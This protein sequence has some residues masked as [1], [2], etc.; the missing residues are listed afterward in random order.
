V[1][2]RWRPDD[3]D[4]QIL[5][6]GLIVRAAATVLFVAVLILVVPAPGQRL[7]SVAL[8]AIIALE[9]AVVVGW[10]LRRDCVAPVALVLDVPFGAALIVAGTYLTASG[11][12]GDWSAFVLSYTV[13]AS[14]TVGFASRGIGSAALNGLVWGLAGFGS[15]VTIAHQA[16]LA[17]AFLLPSY[18][19]NPIVGATCA[20][21][22][23]SSATVFEAARGAELRYAA[24][25]AE[26]RERVR[27]GQVLHDRILQTMETLAREGVIGDDRVRERVR[28]QAAWLRRFVETPDLVPDGFSERLTTVAR[29][30]ER[31]GTRV[32]LN[33]AA[34]LVHPVVLAPQRSDVVIGSIRRLLA[35]LGGPGARVVMRVTVES[36]AVL[37]TLL[38]LS[39]RGALPEDEVEK[40]RAEVLAVGGELEVEPLPYVQLRVPR[41]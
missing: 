28:A 34:L 24:E 9:S 6:A 31:S 40:V 35:A 14:M 13:L 16:P 4:R 2:P 20:R 12:G 11:L 8:T 15:A 32:E 19:I 7:A 1:I 39:E 17:A 3:P 27:Y 23:R 38:S 41:S 37:L 36:S 30:A 29:E 10:W 33:D 22:L 5:L 21:L 18:L 26:S 25:V